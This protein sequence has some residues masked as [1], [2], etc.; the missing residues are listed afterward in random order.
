MKPVKRHTLTIRKVD[1]KDTGYYT[2]R[3]LNERGVIKSKSFFVQ[4]VLRPRIA[5]HSLND[6]K[7]SVDYSGTVTFSCVFEIYPMYAFTEYIKWQKTDGEILENHKLKQL[8][9]T[10]VN[11]SLTLDL[12]DAFKG[13]N[14]TYVCFIDKAMEEIDKVEAQFSLF[15]VGSPSISIDFVKAIGASKIFMNWTIDN[16]NDPSAIISVLYQEEKMPFFIDYW[17]SVR[18]QGSSKVLVNFKV[19]SRYRF[20]V[21]IE[22]I[23]GTA[24][25]EETD[26]IETLKEDPIYIPEV[27]LLEVSHN[28]IFIGWKSPPPQFLEFFQ[29]Y[30]LTIFNSEKIILK[31][32]R[33]ENSNFL[34][35]VVDKLKRN[36]QYELTVRGCSDL[37]KLCGPYSKEMNVTT[38]DFTDIPNIIYFPDIKTQEVSSTSI[39]I[40]WIPLPSDVLEF[41]D[42]YEIYV[43]RN[44]FSKVFEKKVVALDRSSIVIADLIP[45]TTYF[46]EMRVCN[47][48]L[49]K[50]GPFSHI[51]RETTLTK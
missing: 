18:N 11:T 37:T 39:R 34:H 28:S 3:F 1:L 50:C 6:I 17:E 42:F 49:E 47:G 43:F 5:G 20:K 32:I 27:E 44:C 8:N 48:K 41:F 29:Y 33:S 25:S 40:D 19:S 46:I 36:T 15:V 12:D 16:G 26:W 13:H 51:L 31:Q 38:T 10:F 9:K 4:S 14:G 22:N 45:E 24:T 2:C 30:E 21:L 7:I 35:Y 23:V